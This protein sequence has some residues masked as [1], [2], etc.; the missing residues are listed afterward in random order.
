MMLAQNNTCRIQEQFEDI[1][2]TH[3]LILD[4][5]FQTTSIYKA[6]DSNSAKFCLTNWINY[7]EW[8]PP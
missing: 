4:T 7:W 8:N 3:P 1:N 6:L 2:N 5:L